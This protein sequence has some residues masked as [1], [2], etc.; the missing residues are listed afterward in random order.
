MDHLLRRQLLTTFVPAGLLL[1]GLAVL[2]LGYGKDIGQLMREPTATAGLHPLTGLVSNLGVLLWAAAAA[3][4]FFSGSIVRGADRDSAAGFMFSSGCLSAYLCLDDFFQI[5]EDLVGRYFG[6]RERYVY[7]V[8]AIAVLAYL[9]RYRRLI[10][11]TNYSVLM[12]SFMFLGASVVIDDFFEPWM[13]GLG[14]G[15][16][17]IEDGAKWLGIAAWCSYHVRTA[18]GLVADGV[19]PTGESGARQTGP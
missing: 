5:H 13:Q 19:L 14:Q 3:I 17:L 18:C 15:R 11:R 12:I 6:I 9:L 7:V 1:A 4:S 10:L 8:L 2:G 16:I